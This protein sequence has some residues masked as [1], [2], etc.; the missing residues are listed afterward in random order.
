MGAAVSLRSASSSTNGSCAT[1]SLSAFH[2]PFAT[3][4]VS[5]RSTWCCSRSPVFRM[6]GSIRSPLRH[7]DI[8][9]GTASP[10]LLS[11]VSLSLSLAICCPV[12]QFLSPSARSC[13]APTSRSVSKFRVQ[14]RGLG[15]RF[16][17][18]TSR[19]LAFGCRRCKPRSLSL[20]A[21]P[22]CP[23]SSSSSSSTSHS[24]R[25]ALSASSACAFTARRR[26]VIDLHHLL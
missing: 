8:S 19:S 7:L 26:P 12:L 20:F 3:R 5:S 18:L 15:S 17:V 13:L 14:V 1:L 2:L 22:S 25:M 6:R 9:S 24:H 21:P 23:C 11:Q 4:L 16:S 10:S